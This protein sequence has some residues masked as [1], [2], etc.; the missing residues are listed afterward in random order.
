MEV[1]G[2]H[3]TEQVVEADLLRSRL[4]GKSRSTDFERHR[5]AL[6]NMNLLRDCERDAQGEAIAPILI[7]AVMRLH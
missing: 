3:L 1:F 6:F 4:H 7:V 5:I 2:C